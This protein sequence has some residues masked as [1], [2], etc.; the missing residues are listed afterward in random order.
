MNSIWL[1]IQLPERFDIEFVF[2]NFWLCVCR[3]KKKKTRLLVGKSQKHS[4]PVSRRWPRNSKPW[5]YHF[6]SLNSPVSLKTAN[7]SVILLISTK[8]TSTPWS[9]EGPAC[10]RQLMPDICRWSSNDLFCHHTVCTHLLFFQKTLSTVYRMPETFLDPEI[11]Q[12]QVRG[13]PCS[14]SAWF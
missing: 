1:V 9:P 7:R 3:K 2:Q 6:H 14:H 10:P 12:S 4:G 5:V 8:M 13:S 11:Q